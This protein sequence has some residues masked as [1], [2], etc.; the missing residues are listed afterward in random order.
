MNITHSTE[1]STGEKEAVLRLWN[2]EYGH[3]IRK[4]TVAELDIYFNGLGDLHHFLLRDDAGVVH[5]WAATFTRN[6]DR[7]FAIII[8]GSIQRR[9]YGKQLLN[10]LKAHEEDLSGWVVD[11]DKDTKSDGSPYISPMDFYLKNGFEVLP[12][13]RFESEQ[14]SAVR[15]RWKKEI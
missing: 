9:G 1:L 6:N 12:E 15:I 5:A 7:W 11:H 10:V 13:E 2:N 3:K 4:E 8:D 14:M